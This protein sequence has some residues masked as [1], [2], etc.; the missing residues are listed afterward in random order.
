MREH[1]SKVV[2][3]NELVRIE[4]AAAVEREVLDKAARDALERKRR[5]EETAA[6]IAVATMAAATPPPPQALSS[7]DEAVAFQSA[8]TFHSADMMLAATASRPEYSQVPAL[9][10]GQ[11]HVSMTTSPAVPPQSRDPIV[12]GHGSSVGHSDF[13]SVFVPS[14]I[15]ESMLT[16]WRALVLDGTYHSDELVGPPL[17]VKAKVI[18]RKCGS[19]V[20][21]EFKCLNTL[22]FSSP[23]YYVRPIRLLYSPQIAVD[24][25][26]AFALHDH[27]ALV[28]EKGIK[29]LDDTLKQNPNLS[30]AEKVFI[31]SRVIDVVEQA[32]LNKLVLMDL[33]SANFMKF[34]LGDDVVWKGIDLDGALLIGQVL[35]GST[36]KS[37]AECMPPELTTR[38][39][40]VVASPS[41]DI[42]A[43][44]LLA[45]QIFSRHGISNFW[46][47]QGQYNETSIINCLCGLTQESVYRVIAKEYPGDQNSQ[48]RHFLMHVLQVNSTDRPSTTVLKQYT[49]LCG[50]A[51]VS[52][53]MIFS[54]MNSMDKKLD[55]MASALRNFESRFSTYSIDMKGLLAG[56]TESLV[57]GNMDNRAQLEAIRESNTLL[58]TQLTNLSENNQ[59]SASSLTEV[60]G[61]LAS[62]VDVC[63]C[64]CEEN[65]R[66]QKSE[67]LRNKKTTEVLIRQLHAQEGRLHAQVNDLSCNINERNAE[68]TD[69][70]REL[71]VKLTGQ[72]KAQLTSVSE[73]VSQILVKTDLLLDGH[74]SINAAIRQLCISSSS[75]AES[76]HAVQASLLNLN[77]FLSDFFG[78]LDRRLDSLEDS[79]II[80]TT[81]ARNDI[82]AIVEQAA[83][84][85]TQQNIPTVGAALTSWRESMIGVSDCAS[86]TAADLQC[87]MSSMKQIQNSLQGLVEDM[88]EVKLDLKDLKSAIGIQTELLSAVLCGRYNVPALPFVTPYRPVS[89]RERFNPKR[90]FQDEMRLF[91]IC[92]ITM[93][94]A[95]SGI[96]GPVGYKLTQPKAWVAKIAPLIL[97]CTSLLKTALAVYGIPLPIP[98][99]GEAISQLSFLD[100]MTEGLIS[101]VLTDSTIEDARKDVL[102]TVLS[103]LESIKSDAT[104]EDIFEAGRE[105]SKATAVAYTDLHKLLA[106]LEG[107]QAPV[108]N[109]WYEK[110]GCILYSVYTC[111]VVI[112]DRSIQG[113]I[114]KYLEQRAL[115]LPAVL[116]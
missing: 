49:L 32:H 1:A 18:E 76:I 39:E 9:F 111:F 80:T 114:L 36:F 45:F 51:S 19:Q 115:M 25:V 5:Q 92:P 82:I 108:S 3:E 63:L 28:M 16:G 88:K 30:Y 78:S 13:V 98:P 56:L 104:V 4:M 95:P 87:M 8:Y 42:W 116:G 10:P 12:H 81:S 43:I 103:T 65:L 37:S 44:G 69:S 47:V 67:S 17:I 100:N 48:L 6:L 29:T 59:L 105:V 24:A 90:L 33:K 112:G 75:S 58:I 97:I 26:S 91:F 102:N 110:Y 73:N 46:T 66:N 14:D 86:I 20:E 85:C 77:S 84:M 101:S 2:R 52:A 55:L 15:D 23:G 74:L 107:E 62:S 31:L 94:V 38:L 57:T 64:T 106:K 34:R 61:K 68:Q 96:A 22:F 40:T 72:L 53:S 50:G 70:T 83:E 7:E 54:K 21:H 60:L 11:P 89:S 41:I 71:L 35:S 27:V 113:S 79:T 109:E 99:F 93:Q